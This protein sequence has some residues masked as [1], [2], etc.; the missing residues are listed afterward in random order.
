MNVLISLSPNTEAQ[1]VRAAC[2]ALVRPHTWQQPATSTVTSKLTTLFPH[3]EAVL[4]SSGRSGIAAALQALGIGS[5]DEVIVQAFTCVAVPG[6]VLWTGATPV[7]ADIHPLTYNLDIASVA[8][9]ITTHTRAII[10]Q[11]T[12][13]IPGPV[14]ELR[15]LADQHGLFL[16]EDMAHYLQAPA[17]PLIGHLGVLSFGRDKIISAV[18]GGAVVTGDPALARALRQQQKKLAMPP[19]WWTAQ[20][21]LHP[22]ILSWL[23][24]PWYFAG[25]GKATLVAAQRLKLL[26]MAV[27]PIE[28]TG[29][30]PNFLAWQFSPGLLPLLTKQLARLN[31][32]TQRRQTTVNQYAARLSATSHWRNLALLRVPLR[33]RDKQQVLL[34]ARRQRLLLGDWY[35]T[36][37]EP[38]RLSELEKVN[39]SL[40]N[41]PNAEAATREVINLPTYPTL[42]PFEVQR[43]I[44]FITEHVTVL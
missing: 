42:K 41:C 11:H 8:A 40:G 4:T 39:Y 13:G 36:V 16:I 38:C 32:F 3:T 23:V 37:V 28:R 27:E 31:I 5:G 25:V 6:A 34:E 19:R 14:S 7:Y 20:Q 26:S 10:V 22:I 35:R 33:V 2:A 1:D 29:G 15:V 12:F 44:N 17:P 21:L 18:F 43:V 24:K 30:K 9:N